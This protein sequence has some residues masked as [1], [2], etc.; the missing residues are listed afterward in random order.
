MNRKE[1]YK[2]IF[3]TYE[4][5][6]GELT[7][8]IRE[9]KT[10]KTGVASANGNGIHCFYGND[11]GSDDCFNLTLDE[12]SDRF[13]IERTID[14]NTLIA[15]KVVNDGNNYKLEREC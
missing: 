3:E 4:K 7:I 1:L 2:N 11:D 8:E 9:I 15:S 13:D 12:F 10:N 6:G 14:E 5:L